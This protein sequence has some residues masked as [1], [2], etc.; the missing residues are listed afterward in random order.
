MAKETIVQL[1][2]DIDGGLAVRTIQFVWNA[3]T[4]E[5]DLNSKNAKAFEQA[6]APYVASARRLTTARR[7]SVKRPAAAAAKHDLAAI[8]AWAAKNGHEIAARG[9]ISSAVIDAFHAAESA[10]ANAVTTEAKPAKKAAP[11]TAAKKAPARKAAARKATARKS[12]AR[13]TPAKK[14]AR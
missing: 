8:R 10:V 13:K 3:S 6:L 5:I 7:A 9:R 1:R 4:Y 11:R 14:T 2:D 12:T